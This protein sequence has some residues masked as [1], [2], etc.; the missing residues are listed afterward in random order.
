MKVT[1]TLNMDVCG[2]SYDHE[3]KGCDQKDVV[4]DIESWLY[5][6]LEDEFNDYDLIIERTDGYEFKVSM[7]ID[8]DRMSV[9]TITIEE[10]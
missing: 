2:F 1:G 9:G 3:T 5:E 8:C 7:Y 10:L 6:E 4:N